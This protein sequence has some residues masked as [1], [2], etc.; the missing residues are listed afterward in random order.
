MIA[1]EYKTAAAIVRIHDDC[2][3][4]SA[5]ACLSRV[6]SVVSASCRRRAAQQHTA[7]AAS[8][9]SEKNMA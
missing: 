3:E 6:S 8:Q 5:D 1:A 9:H 4:Y 7:A 2:C